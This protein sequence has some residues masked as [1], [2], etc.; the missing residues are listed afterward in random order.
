MNSDTPRTQA[1]LDTLGLHC[2]CSEKPIELC[3]T[4]E[5]ELAILRAAFGIADDERIPEQKPTFGSVLVEK[6]STRRRIAPI[7]DEVIR[8]ERELAAATDTMR[9][10]AD[11]IRTT[12]AR[13]SWVSPRTKAA[14]AKADE[15]K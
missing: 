7:D 5:L 12:I 4:L 14:L 1:M 11:I 9:E 15:L 6:G 2:A 10:L 3:H 13:G 8:L